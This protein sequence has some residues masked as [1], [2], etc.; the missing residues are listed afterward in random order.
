MS[1]SPAD[2][3]LRQV[4]A[5]L[6]IEVA[7]QEWLAGL[8]EQTRQESGQTVLDHPLAE[9][10]LDLAQPSGGRTT[11]D[12]GAGETWVEPLS[13]EPARAVP[14]EQIP[15][16]PPRYEYLG[17]IGKGAV[18]EV[19]RVLD[20]ALNRVVA[21]K[22]LRR[23]HSRS[24][25]ARHRFLTEAQATAQLEHPGIIPVHDV[26]RLPDDRPFF[27]MKVVRGQTL[28]S[29]VQELHGEP[30]PGVPP[31]WTLRRVLGAFRTVCEAMS[32]A[33]SAGVVHRDLKPANIMVGDFGEVRILDWGLARVLERPGEGAEAGAPEGV[34]LDPGEDGSREGGV[35]GTPAYM[36]PE[37]ARG[38]LSAVGTPTDVYAL[39]AVLYE[40]ISGHRPY[41]DLPDHEVIA[42]V[43]EGPP[44]PPRARLQVP[45]VLQRICSHAMA[46]DPRD[47]YPDASA[48]AREIAAFLDGDRRRSQA[49]RLVKEAR[50]LQPE[51]ASLRRRADELEDEAAALLGAL[52]LHAPAEDKAPGWSRQDA[53]R[54][55]RLEAARAEFRYLE[56]LGSALGHHAEL[57]E[58]RELLAQH[59]RERHARAEEAGDPEAALHE[60]RLR[61]HD[62]G[63]HAAYL[64]GRGWLSLETDPPGA[65]VRL[66]QFVP[67][68]RRL[69]LRDQG[70][71][72]HT[73][74][75]RH[76]LARGSYLL[77][78]RHPDRATVRL[79]VSIEREAD[80]DR[81]PPGTDEA[82][83]VWLPPASLLGPEDRYVPAG[84]TRLGGDPAAPTGRPASRRWLDPFV[85]R[86][87]PVTNREYIA[88]LDDL[89][90]RGREA[91]ALRHAPQQP[92]G[93]GESLGAQI[94]GRHPDGRFFLRP[95]GDGDVWEP[96]WP[97]VLVDRA[98]AEAWC[99]WE[100]ARTGQPWRLPGRDEWEKAGRG[101][102]ARPLPWGDFLDPTFCCMRDSHAARPLL[103]PVQAFPADESPYGVRGLA[104]NAIDWV[105][106]E[107]RV[108]SGAGAGR[109]GLICGGSWYSI[110]QLVRLANALQTDPSH[111]SHFLGFRAARS[112]D[113][114]P[115]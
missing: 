108:G 11:A 114:P 112:L 88:F 90:A 86:R 38:E 103:A 20:H 93:A 10:S 76:P 4:L 50:R 3:R 74:I 35:A 94:D 8:V 14:L 98:G 43:R 6:G 58:A 39:G 99:A 77:E 13:S 87:H 32:F 31:R 96:D 15:A 29:V 83:P 16:L 73:P 47:R 68:L 23:R 33:H 40:I 17:P 27:T 113:R 60:L 62:T 56:L 25:R 81:I 79:P 30:A 63:R 1:T 41:Q 22:I 34:V 64:A 24:A 84:W 80:W 105:R 92:A 42:A 18:G 61:S 82:L 9:A 44:E 46:R 53:A 67:R 75:R 72:G 95:D 55:R 101:V 110:P 69:V 102:D 5:E 59:W 36:A 57:V 111:R 107:L 85:I 21:M 51:I 78:L 104:G 70:S 115:T 97:V 66:H 71:L 91:E 7:D 45:R 28:R 109:I 19:V 54:A 48:L 26:G 49:A 12:P 37:Q 2:Q 52:P 100:A 106:D 89:V 65:E